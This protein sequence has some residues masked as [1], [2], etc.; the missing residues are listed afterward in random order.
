M[1]SWKQL[2]NESATTV[3][4]AVLCQDYVLCDD[5]FMKNDKIKKSLSSPKFWIELAHTLRGAIASS[6]QT[7]ELD[8]DDEQEISDNVILDFALNYENKLLLNDL[9]CESVEG[10]LSHFSTKKRK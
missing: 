6:M 4:L 5:E 10:W 2:N 9:I 3:A 7:E 1:A 8:Y